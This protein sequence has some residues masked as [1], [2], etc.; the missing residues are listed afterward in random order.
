MKPDHCEHCHP[1]PTE[2]K[3]PQPKGWGGLQ[4]RLNNLMNHSE[5]QALYIL[6]QPYEAFPDNVRSKAV[7]IASAMQQR[8]SQSNPL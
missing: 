8:L 1:S 5:E 6:R 3:P 2:Q 7:A 4:A